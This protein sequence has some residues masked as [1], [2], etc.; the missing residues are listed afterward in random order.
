ML[1]LV[2]SWAVK[3]SRGNDTHSPFRVERTTGVISD[4]FL[5]HSCWRNFE[6]F[7]SVEVWGT[8]HEVMKGWWLVVHYPVLHANFP[9]S[10]SECF[11]P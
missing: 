7:I 9:F 2:V 10:S 6:N 3:C 11:G 5:F 4:F 8:K 1:G